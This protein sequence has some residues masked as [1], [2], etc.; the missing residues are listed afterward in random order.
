MAGPASVRWV[1]H[2]QISQML[3]ALHLDP[4]VLPIVVTFNTLLYFNHDPTQCCPP[5]YYTVAA[6]RVQLC[7]GSGSGAQPIQTMIYAAWV[8]PGIYL[9]TS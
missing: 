2:I 6:D 8:S 5:G 3:Q 7:T 1:S 9:N 4:H